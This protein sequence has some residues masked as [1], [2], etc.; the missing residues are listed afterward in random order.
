M[1]RE[2]RRQAGRAF[3]RIDSLEGR[4]GQ[5]FASWPDGTVDRMNRLAGLHAQDAVVQLNL[6][7][8]LFWSGL[9]G[10]RDAW[11][12]AAAS[13]PDTAY[14]VVAGNLLHPEYAKSLPDLRHDGATAE[15]ARGPD[16]AAAARAAPAWRAADGRRASSST[17]S[18]CNGSACSARRSGSSRRPPRG[19][20]GRRGAGRGGRGPV[21]QGATRRM[22]SR[23]SARSRGASRTGRRCGSISA[24]SCSGRVR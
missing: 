21:R 3:A 1:R 8:A 5:A 13:E 12:A 18:R 4:V 7:V 11:R 2:S 23:V 20:R 24:C 22:P 17:A 10:A 14:A 19:A 16:A 6:G 15:R 9:S